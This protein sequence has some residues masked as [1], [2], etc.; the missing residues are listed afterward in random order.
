MYL[1]NMVYMLT[2][3]WMTCKFQ[4]DKVCS[5]I[6]VVVTD[7]IQ[8]DMLDTESLQSHYRT[9]QMDMVYMM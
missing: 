5:S 8:S 9:D 6:A 4:L 3:E 1:V 7:M 2:V